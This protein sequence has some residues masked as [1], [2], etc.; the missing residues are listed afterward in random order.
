MCFLDEPGILVATVR[1]VRK[2]GRFVQAYV[3]EKG[4]LSQVVAGDSRSVWRLARRQHITHN[5]GDSKSRAS[6]RD[7]TFER[8]RKATARC[9][10]QYLRAGGDATPR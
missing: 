5:V 4:N 1:T 3:P 10:R 9:R 2:T 8:N 6:Q 7:A